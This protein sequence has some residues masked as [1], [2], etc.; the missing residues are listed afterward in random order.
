MASRFNQ[1]P[2]HQ[3]PLDQ[4]E[5]PCQVPDPLD[6]LDRLEQLV[7]EDPVEQQVSLLL[8]GFLNWIIFFNFWIQLDNPIALKLKVLKLVFIMD[9]REDTLPVVLDCTTILPSQLFLVIGML[10]SLGLVQNLLVVIG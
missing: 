4:L 9:L 3:V 6:P 2:D 1:S 7:Q 10:L 5:L 8:S